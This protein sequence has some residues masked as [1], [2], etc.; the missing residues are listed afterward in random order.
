MVKPVRVTARKFSWAAIAVLI[1]SACFPAQ[2]PPT[3]VPSSSAS[4]RPMEIS[5]RIAALKRRLESG[6]DHALAEFWQEV[7][8]T[9]TPLIEPAKDKPHHVIVTFLWRGDANIQSVELQAPLE[10]APGFPKFPLTRLLHTDVWYKCWEVR[11][12]LRFGYRFVTSLKVGNKEPRLDVTVVPLNPSNMKFAF[13]EKG[14]GRMELSIAAM[15]FGQEP[16]WNVKQPNVPTGR[17]EAHQFKSAILAREKK[18]WIYTPPV[19]EKSAQNPYGLLVL[20]DG[21]AYQNWF[22]TP[23]ILDNMIHAGKMPPLI[24]VMIDNPREV[25]ISELLY[26]PAF[27]EF[28]SKELLPWVHEHWNVTRDPSNTI[29]GGYSAGGA[30]AAFFALERPDVFGNVLSQS[31]A[32]WQGNKD[33]KWEW[34][35]SSYKAS[36][37][38]PVRFFL[39]A[40]VL[41]DISK[42]GPTLLAANRRF[43]EVLKSKG[44]AATYE[45]V[46]GTHEPVHWRGTLA[47]GLFALAG[48][49]EK[50][51]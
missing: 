18:I 27:V 32:F 37:K 12:D 51:E 6:D 1:S 2:V 48:V 41:E 20:F 29:V 26:N 49:P 47:K 45:E 10:N 13:D 19:A 31:G 34:L 24:A 38:L 42:D 14:T 39:E 40:G 50:A 23:T 44:Y 4:F 33:V 46:G 3:G 7:T 22:P 5:P 9:G 17:V 8:R 21:Y 28:V 30:A 16:A 43:V 15:P 35:T 25:R 11:D 36:P